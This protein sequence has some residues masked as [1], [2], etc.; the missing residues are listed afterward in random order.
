MLL[1]RIQ[2]HRVKIQKCNPYRSSCDIKSNRCKLASEILNSTIP[3][4]CIDLND[5][6]RKIKHRRKQLG[7][8]NR[9]AQWKDCERYS[10]RK[11]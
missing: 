9:F 6:V 5:R 3:I 1:S 10:E 2:I 7:T 11:M 4:V 8:G